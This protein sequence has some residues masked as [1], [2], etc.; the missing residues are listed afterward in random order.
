MRCLR[1]R[2]RFVEIGRRDILSGASLDL[3]LL[4]AGCSF[5][6]YNPDI[7]AVAFVDAFR[8]VADLIAADVAKPLPVHA[9]DLENVV[10]AFTFMARAQH[11]GKVV[12]CRAGAQTPASR[13]H[14][15]TNGTG[16][17]GITA[18]IG[19]GALRDALAK[20]EAVVLVTRR[21]MA[22]SSSDE[23]LVVA[24]HVLEGSRSGS[25]HARPDLGYGFVPLEGDTEELLGAIWATLLSIE[26]VGRED[27]FLDL[28]GDSLYATQAVAR[29][30]KEFGVRIAP[31]GVLGD[32]PLRA[33]A[34]QIDSE[35]AARE[36]KP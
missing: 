11:V 36:T 3:S 4:S 25:V 12:I 15:T 30:K 35:L 24:T 1:P 22:A 16:P 2:G 19:L 8:A 20:H 10:D 7:N 26:R 23:E 34:E 28:G 6:T 13:G 32:V 27:R 5:S 33:L 21:A 17:E 9:F 29:I 14:G 18:P 31:A